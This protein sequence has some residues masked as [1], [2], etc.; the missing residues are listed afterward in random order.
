M[1]CWVSGDPWSRWTAWFCRPKGRTGTENTAVSAHI[2]TVSVG[3][4]AVPVL[5]LTTGSGALTTGSGSLTTG[6]ALV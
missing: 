1:F 6:S 5:Q 2:Q 4:D 3:V